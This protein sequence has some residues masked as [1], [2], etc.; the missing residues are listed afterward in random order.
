MNRDIAL[1][2][3]ATASV[4]GIGGQGIL[5]QTAIGLNG[6]LLTAAVLAAG[7]WIADRGRRLDPADAWIPIA[8]VLVAAGMAVRS[9]PFTLLLDA[10]GAAALTGASMAAFGGAAVTR[11]SFAAVAALGAVVAGW[12]LVG[13]LKVVGAAAR[14]AGRGSTGRRVPP[15][16]GPI[17]R[18]LLLAV[19]VLF[20]FG[21][22]F[23]SADAVFATIAGKLLNWQIDLGGVVD[24]AGLAFGIAWLVAGLLAVAGGIDPQTAPDTDRPAPAMQSLGAAVASPAPAYP[25]LGET[26]AVTVLAAVVGLFGLFV[27]LQLAYLFGGLDTLAAAGITYAEYARRGFFELVAV[28]GLAAG[29][30]IVL[31]GVVEHRG[32]PFVSAALVLALLTAAILVS[33]A[34]RLRLYQEAYGWTE[35]RLYVYATIAWMGIGIA[36]GSVLLARDRLRW[37]GHFLA[38]AAVAV[39]VG[40]NVVGAERHV[41]NENAARLLDPARVPADGRTGLDV[42]YA[43]SLGDDAVP[44]L[45]AALPA[46]PVADRAIVMT[47]LADRWAELNRPEATG[48]PAWNLAR[49]R[50]RDA[51]RPL[52]V[53]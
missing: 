48:W 38:I 9:D 20:V 21:A 31:H 25:R 24:R 2:V 4:I 43:I 42:R 10:A 40:V 26:E 36:G 50:A 35:L 34:L 23:A 19:P 17:A 6:V 7:W 30:V 32:R 16:V 5:V 33:A 8:A 39:L 14:V 41:A 3:L 37:L 44:A 28:T 22:L 27:G 11:R 13:I 29:L 46:L 12:A 49:E 45:V 51:L 47:D 52:F 53:P 15:H 1:R 18:G